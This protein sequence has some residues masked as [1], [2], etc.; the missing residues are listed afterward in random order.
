MD[1][2][3][4]TLRE[5][6][7]VRPLFHALRSRTCDFSV[8]GMFMWRDFYHIE[9]ALEQGAFFSRLYGE[10]GDVYYNL[11]ISDDVE[12]A[13]HGLV[14]QETADGGT[15]RFCTVPEEYI[16]L[17]T[18]LER[19]VSVSEQPEFFD[20]LYR[21]ED[22]AGLSGKKYS[23]QRNQ[24]SQ[25][26]RSCATWEFKP[27]EQGDV[28]RVRAFF[29]GRYLGA[30]SDG[31]FEREENAKVLE[32]LDHLDAYGMQGGFLTADG[33][34]V[35]FSLHEI[36]GDTMFTHIEKADRRVKGAYQMLVNQAVAAFA[37]DGVLYINREE[38]MGDPG[39]R[40]S[41]MSYHPLK[42]LK[43]YTIEVR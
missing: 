35:G 10:A 18:R 28:G 31:A 21:A 14:N 37:G 5:T 29:Q 43:K 42:L 1:F 8:G 11:P 30:A 24:I 16:P 2:E 3:P 19:E 40:T 34:V 12:G 17:F 23:G 9:F 25:F 32:V 4:L 15:V 41:K 7:R 22:L 36:V 27:L 20:Y 6:G 13:L 39:L 38:D 26:K 33:K